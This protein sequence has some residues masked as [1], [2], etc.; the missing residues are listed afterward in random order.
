MSKIILR[1]SNKDLEGMDL[2][3]LDIKWDDDYLVF[4]DKFGQKWKLIPNKNIMIRYPFIITPISPSQ[5][6]T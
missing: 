4:E 6:S 1:S 5:S 2:G 3:Y